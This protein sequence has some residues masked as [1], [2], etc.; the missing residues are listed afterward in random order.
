MAAILNAAGRSGRKDPVETSPSS[1]VP[2]TGRA[3]MRREGEA[4][5]DLMSGQSPC[6]A[7][8]AKGGSAAAG[9]DL[10]GRRCC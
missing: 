4:C 6:A 9:G 7:A 10:V 1:W 2:T 3:T 8:K 5:I